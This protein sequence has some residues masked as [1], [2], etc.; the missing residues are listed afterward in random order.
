[1]CVCVCVCVSNRSPTD[2][3]RHKDNL[4]ILTGINLVCLQ[5]FQSTRFV[6]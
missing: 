5:S 4:T 6:S 3:L 1:M 2:S